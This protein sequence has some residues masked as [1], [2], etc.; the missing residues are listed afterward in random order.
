MPDNSGPIAVLC[1]GGDSCGMNACVRSVVRTA[2]F[3]GVEIYGVERGYAGLINGAI[4]RLSAR[5]VSGIINRGGTVIRSARS[6]DFVERGG[7]VRAAEQL[8]GHGIA[9]LV[10]LGGDGSFHGAHFLALEHPS[11]R[12]VGVPCTIDNDI[13]GTDLTIGYDTAVNVAMSA[14]D[15][16]RDTASSHDR[17]FVVEVM[18][19][20]AGH[21]A[22]EVAVA[23]GAEEVFLPETTEDLDAI[24]ARLSEGRRNGKTS[25][26]VVVAEGETQGNAHDIAAFLQNTTGFEVRV[27]ILGYIQRGGIPTATDRVVASRMG[28]AAVEVI[29]DGQSGVYVGIENDRITT[30]PFPFAWEAKKAVDPDRVRV[31]RMLAI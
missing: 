10:V 16:I 9:S 11:L 25:S 26:I 15:K 4:E 13:N 28:A 6:A 19:R 21:I 12:V 22:L 31:L 24:A 1:S 18:G 17:L 27:S 5:S 7:R 14:I 20:H 2:L 23:S 29:L 3:H 8:A 30:H